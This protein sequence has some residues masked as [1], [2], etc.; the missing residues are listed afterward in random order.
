VAIGGDAHV[1]RES[2]TPEMAGEYQVENDG[3]HPL[4]DSLAVSVRDNASQVKGGRITFAN[5][6][7]VD[8]YVDMRQQLDEF[9]QSHPLSEGLRGVLLRVGINIMK[10]AGLL[11]LSEG[12][13][14]IEMEDLLLAMKSGE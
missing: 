14:M 7:V 10:G 11:A 1:T 13:E 5:Q 9:A 4:V 12:R 8:R 2:L 3:R 6:K